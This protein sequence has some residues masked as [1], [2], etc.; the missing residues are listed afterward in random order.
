MKFK[1]NEGQEVYIIHW[2]S[3]NNKCIGGNIE[4]VKVEKHEVVPMEQVVSV[5]PYIEIN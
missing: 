2:T 5:R 3:K 1:Y 4:K